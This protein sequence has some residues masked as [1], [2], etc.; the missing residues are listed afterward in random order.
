MTVPPRDLV[1][2]T[3]L[4]S[5]PGVAFVGRTAERQSLLS[6][7]AEADAGEPRLCLIRGEP[8]V[9]KSRLALEFLAEADAAGWQTLK[10]RCLEDEFSPLAPFLAEVLPRLRQAGILKGRAGPASKTE[11][12]TDGAVLA[13][14]LCQ[15]AAIRPVTLLIDDIQLLA[16]AELTFFRN[17]CMALSDVGRNKP[18]S[19]MVVATVRIPGQN[20]D[21]SD[22]FDRLL[23]EP[24]ARVIDLAGLGQLEANELVRR[25]TGSNCDPLLL[26]F[27]SGATRGN[28]LFLG[29]ALQELSA[30]GAL[31]HAEG[32][33]HATVNLDNLVLPASAPAV[34]RQR[35]ARLPAEVAPVLELAALLGEEFSVAEL[36]AVAGTSEPTLPLDTLALDGVLLGDGERYRFS[37]ALVRQ[38]V[39][40]GIAPARGRA[41]HKKIAEALAAMDGADAGSVLRI[42]E[43]RA[44]ASTRDDIE[45]ARFFEKAGDVAMEAF[46]WSLGV[47]YYARARSNEGYVAQMDARDRGNLYFKLARTLFPCGDIAGAQT[48]FRLAV[49]ELSRTRD[50]D[51]W[52]R[53]LLSW[54]RT[55]A[56]S[57]ER[58]PALGLFE[59]FRRAAGDAVPHIQASLLTNWAQGLWL[60]RDPADLEVSNRSVAMAE[61]VDDVEVRGYAYTVRGLV[62]MRRLEPAPSISAFRRAIAETENISNPIRRNWGRARIALP[63]TL[64][65]SLREANEAAEKSLHDSFTGADWTHAG[66]SLAIL[67]TLATLRGEFAGAA[68]HRHEGA[69][70]VN[71]SG[72]AQSLFMLHAATVQ[73]RLLEG[74]FGE[75][76]DAV[77][78]WKLV[79]GKSIPKPFE[80]LAFLGIDDPFAAQEIVDAGLG[81]PELT[82]QV[83]FSSLSTLCG[84][85]E[86]ADSLNS[87]E[88]AE[89]AYDRLREVQ[90]SGAVFSV[91]PPYLIER[92]M[93]TAARLLGRY[94]AAED[95]AREAIRIA[96]REGAAA[97]GALARLEMLKILTVKDPNR[98]SGIE[99]HLKSAAAALQKLDMFPAIVACRTTAL[100]L[101]L[102]HAGNYGVTV[103]PSELS[104]TEHDVLVSLATGLDEQQAASQLLIHPRT[105]QVFRGRLRKRL[106]ISTRRE[107]EMYLGI[108]SAA[109]LPR[110]PPVAGPGGRL[111][112]RERE[113]LGLI[114][115]GR[116]NQQ[117]A[118]ELFISL[119]TVARHVANIFDKTGAANR[120]EAARYSAEKF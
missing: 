99:V 50:F 24:I 39:V 70:M 97:E 83:D 73:A 4:P 21:T 42:A 107:A 36:A 113:V 53:A 93:A 17:F 78:A 82:S 32:S 92:V 76:L 91:S 79:A 57:S 61:S 13:G 49:E 40:E 109:A 104:R 88:I 116:T 118:D 1:P 101:G 44:Q 19:A 37:H 84:W 7:L 8:G 95:H 33:L 80:G 27:F 66:L 114:A 65:G 52:G 71:R 26:E 86:L 46:A 10:G 81:R 58:I 64:A 77:Q 15:L 67:S 74:E 106:G 29:E 60:N 11:T 43:H 105:V 48:N 68:K 72:H 28:P 30:R 25:M 31:S 34:I 98:P 47:R 38:A 100:S 63:L 56:N 41:L 108:D 89:R 14:M 62:H 35:I 119:H 94:L 115:R 69:M 3:V 18:T 110:T 45:A 103:P 111:S 59:D 6:F 54:E 22:T 75:A 117:I 23:R 12:I 112:R 96:D 85:I 120:T 16:G 20:A 90:D 87:P 5:S 51:A 55:F 2:A 102:E 9:G